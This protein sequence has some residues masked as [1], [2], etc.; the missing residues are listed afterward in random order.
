MRRHRVQPQTLNTADRTDLRVRARACSGHGRSRQDRRLECQGRRDLERGP[1][2]IDPSHPRPAKR[3][4]AESPGRSRSP[5]P[6][7]RSISR[8]TAPRSWSQASS[9]YLY[10]GKTGGLDTT[11]LANGSHTLTAVAYGARGAKATTSV[12]V[13]V[14]NA[15]PAPP[16][17]ESEPAPPTGGGQTLYW[18]ATIGSQL[19]GTQAP[20]DTNAITQVRGRDAQEPLPRPVLPAFRQLRQLALLLLRLSHDAA[21]KHPP[22]RSDPRPRLELAVDPLE[23]ER[24]RTSSSPT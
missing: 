2:R 1:Q 18:G 22:S 16:P 6:P 8:S 3:S 10:R 5:A 23:P 4:R 15:A 9:P 20:W 11:T 17:A 14:K 21:R 13:N 19:T 24:A 7:A 12:V